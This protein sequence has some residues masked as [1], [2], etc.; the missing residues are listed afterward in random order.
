MPDGDKC[1]IRFFVALK[2]CIDDFLL[3]CKSYIAMDATH[4][5]GRSRGQLQQMLQWMGRMGYFLWHME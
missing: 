2:P 5:T 1:F 3:G 4:L